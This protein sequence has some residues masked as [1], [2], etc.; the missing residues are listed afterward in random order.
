M[1]NNKEIWIDPYQIEE[2][3]VDVLGIFLKRQFKSTS[4][5]RKIND[6]NF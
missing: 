4:K 3:D 2:T 5:I 1:E 6:S